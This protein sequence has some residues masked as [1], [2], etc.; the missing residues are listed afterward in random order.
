MRINMVFNLETVGELQSLTQALTTTN[1]LIAQAKL[2]EDVN[3]LLK[4]RDRL[5]GE[6]ENLRNKLPRKE[7]KDDPKDKC[8][9]ARPAYTMPASPPVYV[10]EDRARDDEAPR[11]R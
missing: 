11:I 10:A 8:E 5:Q 2:T 9:E 7:T 1:N 3:R 6:V 4:E